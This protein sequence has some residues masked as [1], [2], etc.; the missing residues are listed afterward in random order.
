MLDTTDL[1]EFFYKLN[2]IEYLINSDDTKSEEERDWVYR[3]I[4]S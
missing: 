4:A 3:F 1:Y 2:I